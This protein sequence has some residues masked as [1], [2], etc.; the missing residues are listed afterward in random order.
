MHAS[1]VTA[2]SDSLGGY[3]INVSP[4]RAVSESLRGCL[5]CR[6]HA[7][8]VTAVSESLRGCVGCRILASPVTAVFDSLGLSNP[9]VT[10]D[11]SA[12]I[13]SES[14]EGCVG[15]RIHASPVTAVSD[16]LGR[17]VVCRIH[18]S[19]VTLVFDSL[20][21]VWAVEPTRHPRQQFVDHFR[22]PRGLCGLS[23]PRVT[24]DSSF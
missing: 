16:S 22:V 24:R 7:S 17:C 3:R 19:P 18:A 6:I 10:S 20:R 2:V 1:L 12:L 4:V 5:G 13:I 23:N 11:S 14:L 9:R 8:P 15:C 21:A